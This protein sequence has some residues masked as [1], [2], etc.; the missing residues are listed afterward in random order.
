MMRKLVFA[1]L[2]GAALAGCGGK[3]AGPVDRD[4]NLVPWV[5]RPA[6]PYNAPPPKIPRYTT[7]AP[8]CRARELAVGGVRR[9]GAT[10]NLLEEVHIENV[11]TTACLLAG[12]PKVTA[13]TAD[14]T[15][16][17]VRARVGRHGTY[18]G[19][20]VPADI[21]PG[22]HGVLDFATGDACDAHHVHSDRLLAFDLP[23][24]GGVV[25]APRRLALVVECGFLTMSRLGLP[26]PQ[27]S[28]RRPR[29][30][31]PDVLRARIDIPSSARAGATLS[32]V[33]TLTNPTRT[34]VVLTPCPRYEE[35]LYGDRPVE[36]WYHL[37]CD[38]VRRIAPHASVRYAMAV[39]V[40][41]D[42]RP[43]LAKFLW[44]LGSPVTLADGGLITITRS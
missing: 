3:A 4:A 17:P 15:R 8:P 10:G 25:F 26:K 31:T 27:P 13:G 42:A 34:T 38:S 16:V 23:G 22:R 12:F 40:P 2:A 33:V 11:G 36:R 30:G 9:A 29:R 43:G 1:L 32:F 7:S 21:D 6:P 14:G 20:I 18:F 5:D 39:R 44:R 28:E 41:A 37:N 35:A 19:Q 24:D